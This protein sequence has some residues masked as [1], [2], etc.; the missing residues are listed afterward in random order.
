MFTDECSGPA[1]HGAMDVEL[2]FLVVNT[3]QRRL[4][5]RGLDAIARERRRLPFETEVIVLDNA[6]S[7]GSARAAA[8][9]PTV[10]E[11]IALDRR[12]G[13]ADNDSVLL[14][15]ARGRYGLLLNEDSEVLPGAVGRLHAALSADATAAAAGGRLL[16]GDLR[17]QPS[18]WRFPGPA[19]AALTALWLHRSL[20]VQSRGDRVREV[21]W[22]QSAAL[23]VRRDAAAAI[24]WLDPAFFVYY[25]DADFCRRL[26]D[27]GWRVL[28]VPAAVTIHHEQLSTGA[29]PERR[30]VEF[31]RNRDAYVRKHHSAS[32][33]LAV[34]ALTAWAYAVRAAAA[35]AL[36]GHD[37]RRYRR[38]VTATLRPGAGVGLR[39]RAEAFNRQRDEEGG[40]AAARAASTGAGGDARSTVD[41]LR[42]GG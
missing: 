35:V 30:I 14:R 33:A 22:A 34:R 36:P 3:N 2:S 20:V 9:H 23:L 40:P 42:V 18:A 16:R 29:V 7:D 21:D 4:L 24:G 1:I 6:S 39:E 5:L 8:A 10:S 11:V 17:A 31:S 15:R 27:G 25:D 38:H 41:G 13:K 19:T 37:A 28:Y 26:R 12:R 32:A